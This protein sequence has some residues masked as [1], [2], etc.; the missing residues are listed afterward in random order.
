MGTK[1]YPE[2]SPTNC[3][4]H[5]ASNS[6]RQEIWFIPRR[7]PEITQLCLQLGKSL[8]DFWWTKWRWYKFCHCEWTQVRWK[9]SMFTWRTVL[10]LMY[11]DWTWSYK[12][13]MFPALQKNTGYQKWGALCW[14]MML[15][16]VFCPSAF[17]RKSV[18]SKP[19]CQIIL[20]HG[21]IWLKNVTLA[22]TAR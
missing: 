6:R 4:T 19:Q 5:A 9:R 2:M 10:L 1:V 13:I 12:I 17:R 18:G 3:Q 8:S 20:W 16:Q 22:Q 11:P 7:K 15:R 21:V 14:F